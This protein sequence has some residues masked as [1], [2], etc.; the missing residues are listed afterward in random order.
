MYTS[1]ALQFLGILQPLCA[2]TGS[3]FIL[4]LEQDDKRELNHGDMVG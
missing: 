3:H 4:I 1:V 2:D